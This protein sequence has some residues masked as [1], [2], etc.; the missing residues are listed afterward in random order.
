MVKS[1]PVQLAENHAI[2]TTRLTKM[3]KVVTATVLLIAASKQESA[4]PANRNYT[5]IA[6]AMIG[7]TS[8]INLALA[9]TMEIE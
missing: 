8:V 5:K 2:T 3:E 9:A 6:T 7:A 4:K 1:F